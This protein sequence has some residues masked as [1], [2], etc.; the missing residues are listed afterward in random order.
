M[1]PQQ[2]LCVEFWPRAQSGAGI[3]RQ[4]HGLCSHVLHGL[5]S[6]AAALCDPVSPAANKLFPHARSPL[7]AESCRQDRDKRDGEKT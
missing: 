6:V 3:T 5:G 2:C 7:N 1:H 4:Q